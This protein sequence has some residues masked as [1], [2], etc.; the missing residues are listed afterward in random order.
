MFVFFDVEPTFSLK[1]EGSNFSCTIAVN[2]RKSIK[3][4]AV[5]EG[6]FSLAED[7]QLEDMGFKVIK[8]SYRLEPGEAIS[9]D[10]LLNLF[11]DDIFTA[12]SDLVA[13]VNLVFDKDGNA[14]ISIRNNGTPLYVVDDIVVND[15]TGY[16]IYSVKTVEILKEGEQYGSRGGNGVVRITTH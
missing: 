15:L 6:D 9:G 2:G 16:T 4:K 1:I 10:R 13:G 12:L 14:S 3:I 5:S 11:Y 8:E 7:Q